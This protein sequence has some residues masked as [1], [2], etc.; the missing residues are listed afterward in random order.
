MTPLHWAMS[1]AQP[2]GY[3]KSSDTPLFAASIYGGNDFS[4]PGSTTGGST[5]SQQFVVSICDDNQTL[6]LDRPL[7][8][9]PSTELR[10]G[11]VRIAVRDNIPSWDTEQIG[12]EH[13]TIQ[14]PSTPW[15]KHFGTEGQGAIE[16]MSDNSWVR[17][18]KIINADNGIEMNRNTFNNTIQD[19]ILSSDRI[20]RRSGPSGRRYDAYGHHGITLKGRDHMLKD[21]VLEVSFVH[22]VSMNN[23][24]G[25]VVMRGDALQMNM[26]HHRQ[27]IYDS[28]WTELNL[29]IPVRMWES[30]GNPAEGYNS[31]AYNT[32]WNI[33]SDQPDKAY[34]PEDGE[35]GLYPQWGYHNINMIATELQGKPA[36]GEG[37]RPLPYHPDNAH[38]EV[39][40]P[41]EIYPENIYQAQR[42]AY[43][44]GLLFDLHR[45]R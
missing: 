39:I 1:L 8:F 5:V 22:D 45:K 26:D 4:P 13:L 23:C 35:N 37:N 6:I 34:W 36:I 15:L 28:L 25:C 3:G 9:S 42:Q 38:L 7:R 27:G 30:T 12:I 19:V 16:V 33:K 18:I 10:Y 41:S 40:R 17:N 44:H 32:Y 11:G 43:L 14:L 29:G 2:L 21:F 20:P 24:H 31:G